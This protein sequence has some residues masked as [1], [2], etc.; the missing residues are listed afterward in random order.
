VT[1]VQVEARESIEPSHVLHA[2]V[3]QLVEQ[4]DSRVGDVVPACEVV[5]LRLPA[6][7]LRA[8]SPVRVHERFTLTRTLKNS[9]SSASDTVTRE[10]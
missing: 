10:R 4:R 5:Q 1:V 6:S 8:P 2:A 3:A 7:A 9:S